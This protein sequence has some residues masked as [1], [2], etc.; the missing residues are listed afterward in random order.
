MI[1]KGHNAFLCDWGVASHLPDSD[2]VTG[3]H[4]TRGYVP[5]EAALGLTY[6]A[7][8]QDV[9][10]LGYGIMSLRLTLV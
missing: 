9:F 5:F 4:G 8:Y 6:S 2:L 1:D 7:A 10:A 3:L